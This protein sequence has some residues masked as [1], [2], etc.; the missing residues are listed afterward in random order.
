D[1]RFI[2]PADRDLAMAKIERIVAHRHL[3]GAYAMIEITGE[4]RPLVARTDS[5]R[6]FEHYVACANDLGVAVT[7]EFAGGCARSCFAASVGA[8]TI[9]GVGPIGGRAHSPEECPE[10]AS[11]GARAQALGPAVSGP[12]A[13]PSC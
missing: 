6:L 7:G 5:K 13:L 9:C 3:P 12:P 10:N 11:I 8:P 1:L 2:D 4:F